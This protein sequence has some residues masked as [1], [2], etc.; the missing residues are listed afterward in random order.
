V[1]FVG[2]QHAPIS[3][4]NVNHFVSQLEQIGVKQEQIGAKQLEQFGVRSAILNQAPKNFGPEESKQVSYLWISGVQDKYCLFLSALVSANRFLCLRVI[5][6]VC[7]TH[8]D[9]AAG[10]QAI[11]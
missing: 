10:P 5:F 4:E 9:G 6:I 8:T 3:A 7:T 2:V 1:V 11:F